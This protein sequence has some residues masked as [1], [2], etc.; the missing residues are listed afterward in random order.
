MFDMGMKKKGNL[1]TQQFVA[2][3]KKHRIP[4]TVKEAADED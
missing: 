1:K 4:F 2:F 3:C